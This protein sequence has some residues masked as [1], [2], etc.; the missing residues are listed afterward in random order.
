[1]HRYFKNLATAKACSNSYVLSISGQEV[2]VLVG[3]MN[4]KDKLNNIR[5]KFLPFLG[6]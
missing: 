5:I 2:L 4:Q 3:V 1:M 6:P